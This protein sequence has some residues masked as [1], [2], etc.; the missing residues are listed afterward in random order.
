MYSVILP[1]FP[2]PISDWIS[3]IDVNAQ[4]QYPMDVSS[5]VVTP[6][7]RLG[8]LRDD[9]IVYRQNQLDDGT[10]ELSYEPLFVTAL[11]IGL[12]ATVDSNFGLYA[13][14][15]YDLGLKGNIYRHKLDSQIGYDLKN[16]MFVYTGLRSSVRN[17]DI[18][19]ASGSKAGEIHDV[20]QSFLLGFG[21]KRQ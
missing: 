16:G 13:M 20:N 10:T 3:S 11:N 4:G 1:E 5:F 14:G 12:G 17:V 6:A 15:T 21:Y 2:D 8:V 9:L 19:S 18:D 7:V